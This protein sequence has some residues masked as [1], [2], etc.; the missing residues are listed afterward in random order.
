MSG[1]A[2]LGA[3]RVQVLRCACTPDDYRPC[4]GDF[5]S[6]DGCGITSEDPMP[7][8]EPMDENGLDLREASS[9]FY[10]CQPCA[11]AWILDGADVRRAVPS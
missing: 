11:F 6:C 10:Y 2:L 7:Y 8:A 4:N 5:V 3:V 1:L 9:W